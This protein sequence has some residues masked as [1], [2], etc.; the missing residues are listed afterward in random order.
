MKVEFISRRVGS[1]PHLGMSWGCHS[2]QWEPFW[3]RTSETW[4]SVW[5]AG[6]ASQTAYLGGEGSKRSQVRGQQGAKSRLIMTQMSDTEYV[7][8]HGCACVRMRET[9][10][11]KGRKDAGRRH[12]WQ[13]FLIRAIKDTDDEWVISLS[14][15][16]FQHILLVI[17][18]LQFC[19]V[20][21]AD[22]FA[23]KERLSCRRKG[24]SHMTLSKRCNACAH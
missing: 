3:A 4:C 8:M 9:Q 22:M 12:R 18:I 1:S 20:M 16:T 13:H 11:K 17:F 19:L 7:Y 21:D 2:F 23:K 14:L 10:S 6:D 24:E 5:P 15:R